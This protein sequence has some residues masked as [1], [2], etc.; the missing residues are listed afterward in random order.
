MKPV[1]N[2]DQ[3]AFQLTDAGQAFFDESRQAFDL[4]GSR[5]LTYNI[6]GLEAAG[7]LFARAAFDAWSNVSGIRF[8]EGGFFS[9]ITLRH[10]FSNA[11]VAF[12]ETYTNE[13]GDIVDAEVIISESWIAGDWSYMAG[14]QVTVDYASYSMQT[15]VHEI[16]HALGLAHA[17]NYNSSA[18]YNRDASYANDS[19]QASIMSYFS[20]LENPT[21]DADFAYV[22]TPMI[23]D[24]IAIQDL[25]GIR[26]QAQIGDTT[27]GFGSN[28]GTYLDGLA[29]VSEPVAFTIFDSGG[30]DTVNYA[31]VRDNQLIDLRAE[32]ISDVN[33]LKGNMVIARGVT[34]ENAIGGSGDD[35]IMGNHVANV[36]QGGAGADRIGGDDGNDVIVSGLGND[37][38]YGDAG[39]DA[40]T[41]FSGANT[42]WGG[43]GADLLLGG[44]QAD[45]LYGG[46][47]NDVLRG[48][49][50]NGFF[51][52]S[53][54]LVGG[55]GDDTLMGGGG[56]DTFVF[57]RN[58]GNDTIGGFDMSDVDGTSVVAAQRDFEIGV[59]VILLEGFSGL[60]T[61]NI[62]SATTQVGADTVF[63]AQG[64]QITLLGIS[65][66]ALT[67]D[68]FIF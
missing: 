41:S 60:N 29:R 33:G 23:T 26:A 32:A 22:V 4:S 51:A 61:S 50:G 18:T 34:I 13:F 66:D 57:R 58:E 9:D 30:T 46:A 63:E 44:F 59:D 53:D 36:L 49:V 48:D 2:Y 19:W 21:I 11:P 5:I 24:I 35:L 65:V 1:Y 37:T 64:T 15:F 67:A 45:A 52:G 56:A 39:A 54:R 10:G 42:F 55:A 20:Q 40:L 31:S 12:A 16:G 27:Y 47:G 17:G 28:T 43:S 38:S 7:K 62:L 6:T 8:V 14:G 3:I 68:S 25:Y